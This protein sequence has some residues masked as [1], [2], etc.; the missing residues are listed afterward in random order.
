[1]FNYFHKQWYRIELPSSIG[2]TSYFGRN[3]EWRSWVDANNNTVLY[4]CDSA[5]Y[6]FKYKSASSTYPYA[7]TI[8]SSASYVA[9]VSCSAETSW[10]QFPGYGGKMRVYK[11]LMMGTFDP[12]SDGTTT[13]ALSSSTNFNGAA[14]NETFTNT[15]TAAGIGSETQQGSSEV[16]MKPAQQKSESLRVSFTMDSGSAGKGWSPE[17]LL[18]EV[19]ERPSATRFKVDSDKAS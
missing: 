13:L 14:V 1:V 18:F 15:I 6:V 8:L 11:I 9:P 5:G 2:V 12:A 10:L 3:V 7:D 17:G 19:G 4:L 16:V